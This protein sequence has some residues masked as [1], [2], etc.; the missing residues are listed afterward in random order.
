M[1]IYR[2]SIG[3]REYMVDVTDHQVSVNG[4]PMQAEL[5]S[6]N[7]GGLYVLRGGSRSREMHLHALSQKAYAIL[8]NGRHVIAQVEKATSRMRRSS[9]HVDAGDLRAPMPG[10]VIEVLVKEGQLVEAG[11]TLV[12]LESMKMQMRLR[13]P[14]PGRVVK[15]L[16]SAR[17]QV[18]KDTLLVQIVQD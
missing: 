14:I 7:E 3:K 12:V 4:E 15:V 17:A 18:E 6:L 9:A 11:D 2:V 8:V 5:D 1:T 16:A 13:A 10:V